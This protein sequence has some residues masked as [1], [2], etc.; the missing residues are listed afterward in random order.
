MSENEDY[1]MEFL[2]SVEESLLN[3]I[4]VDRLHQ[5]VD[6][7]TKVL[8][9]YEITQRCT[10]LAPLDDANTKIAKRYCACLLVDGK[11]ERT[12]K[13]YRRAIERFSNFMHKPFT[14]IGAYD[15]RYYLACEKERGVSNLTLNNT[16][17]YLSAFYH[18]M[19]T[20]DLISKNPMENIK[21]IKFTEE[22]KLPFSDTEIDSL[23]SACKTEKDRAIVEV[24][25]SSGVR[26]SELSQMNV[27]D[28]DMATL[29]VHVRHGKGDKER[30]TYINSVAA[31][32]LKAYLDNRKDDGEAL[33]YSKQHQRIGISSIR[34]VLLEVAK[35]A[36]VAHVHPHR[37]R[38]TFATG[39]AARGMGVHEIQKLLGHSNIS[40]TME[41]ITVTND[42]VKASYNKYIA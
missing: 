19:N 10:D 12:I 9:E 32:H 35:R 15:I 25:L 30:I 40:T 36:K 33:F 26:V 4:D 29:T 17:G 31:K 39:I 28:I 23:R 7:V 8:S 42:D 16:R 22:V 21:P 6:E 3:V 20:E 27:E 34:Y 14:E 37:F 41:Y 18:W 1:R 11:S 24:L 2:H 38:R 13:Q 5:V